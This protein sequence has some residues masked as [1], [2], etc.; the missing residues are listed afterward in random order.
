MPTPQYT[1]RDE[2]GHFL[3]ARDVAGTFESD[4]HEVDIHVRVP[5]LSACAC[6]VWGDWGPMYTFGL[7]APQKVV[8]EYVCRSR[9]LCATFELEPRS[10]ALNSPVL[11]RDRLDYPLFLELTD[12]ERRICAR[13]YLRVDG[14][15]SH[16][17]VDAGPGAFVRIFRDA[18]VGSPDIARSA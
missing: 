17:N 12:R 10:L 9:D 3:G 13:A 5:D 11:A 2:I 15:F 16:L 7:R 18:D 14:T 1:Q 4:G 6:T 8:F